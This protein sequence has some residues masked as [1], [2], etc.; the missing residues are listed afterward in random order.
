MKVLKQL[1]LLLCLVTTLNS[2]AQQWELK[3]DEDGVTVSVR[4]VAG[5]K[6]KEFKA[7]MVVKTSVE[8]LLNRIKNVNDYLSWVSGCETTKIVETYDDNHFLYYLELG[9]PWPVSNRD[10]A[11]EGTVT[12]K[13]WG[14]LFSMQQSEGK[15]P[16]KDNVK[17]MPKFKGFWKLEQQ[18]DGTVKVTHQVHAE[19][20]GSIPAWLANAKVT[21][22]PLETL[23]NLKA[24]T[25]KS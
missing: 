20:G 19:P 18:G 1:I 13:D 3:K 14:V 23:R 11:I 5:S 4:D 22:G 6:I 17:R 7:E 8:Q 15:V 12:H 16:E 21:D 24:I 10:V 9:A 2:T 25:Q